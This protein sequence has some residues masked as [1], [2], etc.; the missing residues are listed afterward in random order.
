MDVGEC[1]GERGEWKEERGECTD[2]KRRML[3]EAG[4]IW[5]MDDVNPTQGEDALN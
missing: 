2:N 3:V 5:R 1:E 4:M